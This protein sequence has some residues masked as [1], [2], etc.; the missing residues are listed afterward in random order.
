MQQYDLTLKL[1]LQKRMPALLR[2]LRLD[3]V[4]EILTVEFPLHLK[5]LPDMVVRLVDGRILHIE[6][7]TANDPRMVSR[8]LGYWQVIADL[9][10][11][12]EIVQVVVYLGDGLKSMA[13][14][15]KRGKLQYEFDILNLQEVD[16]KAFLESESDVE[17]M[18]AV[19]CRSDDPRAT[20][21]AILA[22]WK[23][24][25]AKEVFENITDLMV[26]SQLR[27]RDTIVHEE[28]RAMPIEIDISQ[29]VWFKMGE[30]CGEARGE[31][32]GEAR[33]EAK[34]LAKFLER[35]FGPLPETVLTRISSADV[36]ALERWADR[37][38][39]ALTL[40]DVFD[41]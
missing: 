21:A 22:S 13:S 39:R 11:H 20:I 14:G 38:E 27:K 32:K 25:P 19:L 29:N 23:H 40:N 34:L 3:G 17:R 5:V 26:L 28:S 18:L 31:A 4:A 9:W 15:V 30:E 16:A 41:A 8:C 37:L 1:I 36:E 10:P 6:F 2:V 33:G 24:L 7:Q 35:R 12:G